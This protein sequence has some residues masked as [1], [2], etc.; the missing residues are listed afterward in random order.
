MV[1][2]QSAETVLFRR[3]TQVVRLCDLWIEVSRQILW[4]RFGE[5]LFKLQ[6][7]YNLTYQDQ[8]KYCELH[9]SFC[10]DT[11]DTLEENHLVLRGPCRKLDKVYQV[12]HP[13]V[14]QERP[15]GK[16]LIQADDLVAYPERYVNRRFQTVLLFIRNEE[17]EWILSPDGGSLPVVVEYGIDQARL[18]ELW[19]TGPESSAETGWVCIDGFLRRYVEWWMLY[20]LAF[21]PVDRCE[22]ESPRI[23]SLLQAFRRDEWL[24][25]IP[26]QGERSQNGVGY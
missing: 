1:T 17:D 16:E 9:A 6:A 12:L 7:L 8:G 19:N 14:L 22:N 18:Y 25:F 21:D 5:R 15:P 11:V 3:G 13:Y 26:W 20:V 10:Q 4:W 2:D 24:P 23:R